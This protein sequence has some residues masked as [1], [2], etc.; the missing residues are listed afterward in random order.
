MFPLMLPR[1]G[2]ATIHTSLPFTLLHLG[3]ALP[4]TLPHLGAALA[5]TLP[6]LGAA[7]HVDD[8]VVP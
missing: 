7:H 1:L 4:C 6:H 8:G 5:F 3:A 2:A